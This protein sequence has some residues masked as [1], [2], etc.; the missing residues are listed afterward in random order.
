MVK[1]ILADAGITA[2]VHPAENKF[3]KV[4]VATMSDKEAVIKALGDAVDETA[5]IKFTNDLSESK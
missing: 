2:D 3:D 5:G 1:K 4:H